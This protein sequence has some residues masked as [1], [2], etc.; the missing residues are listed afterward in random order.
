MVNFTLG[1]IIFI[2]ILGPI[3]YDNCTFMDVNWPWNPI[4]AGDRFHN[5]ST[6]V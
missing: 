6:I 5:P 4:E 2:I 3:P 1:I